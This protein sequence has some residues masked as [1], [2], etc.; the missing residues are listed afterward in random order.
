LTAGIVRYERRRTMAALTVSILVTATLYVTLGYW[1]G[2]RWRA[3]F[4]MWQPGYNLVLILM[5]IG[6]G[7]IW[8]VRKWRRG[9]DGCVS[10]K[11]E[12]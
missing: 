5:A 2:T 10:E 12:S 3:L 8:G 1:L 7:G 6:I 9:R 4:E 11:E